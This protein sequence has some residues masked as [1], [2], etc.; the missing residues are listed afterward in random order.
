MSTPACSS[1]QPEE[2]GW[3][4]YNAR[5]PFFLRGGREKSRF[6]LLILG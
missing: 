5:N 4:I 2:E 3:I 6:K 1:C